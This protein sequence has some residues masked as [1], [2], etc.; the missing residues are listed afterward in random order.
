M[1]A[2]M[3]RKVNA[4][5]TTVCLLVFAVEATIRG[6]DWRGLPPAAQ[7]AYVAGVIDTWG[8]VVGRA[9][10]GHREPTPNELFY[11]QLYECVGGKMPYEQIIAIVKKYIENNPAQWHARMADLVFTALSEPCGLTGK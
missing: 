5:L 4:F 11:K 1:E 10:K 9:I 8:D 7:Q 3:A 2:G 6:N